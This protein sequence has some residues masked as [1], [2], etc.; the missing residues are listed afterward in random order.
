[1]FHILRKYGS[2]KVAHSW[3]VW[4]ISLQDPKL[5]APSVISMLPV[6]VSVINEK[7]KHTHTHTHT[8]RWCGMWCNVHTKFKTFYLVKE[9][10][11]VTTWTACLDLFFLHSRYIRNNNYS[12]TT[13][14][15]SSTRVTIVTL[16]VTKTKI[17]D[18]KTTG[19][20]RMYFGRKSGRCS[21]RSNRPM[22]MEVLL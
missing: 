8:Q 6:G 10:I 15:I 11:S 14:I 21:G 12:H 9:S 7:K 18:R 2:L 22:Q 16:Y 5:S 17:A 19:C 1:M 20:C 3:K 4:Y 13:T